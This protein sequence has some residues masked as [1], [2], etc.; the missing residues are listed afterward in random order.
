MTYGLTTSRQSSL[1]YEK[2][3]GFAESYLVML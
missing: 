2:D 1:N 3:G